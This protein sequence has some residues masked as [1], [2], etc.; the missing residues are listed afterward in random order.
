M[1]LISPDDGHLTVFNLFETD[2]VPLQENVL[3]AMRD[4]IDN[5]DYPGWISSTLHAGVD[6]PG[7]VNYIQWRS[8]ADLQAR[9]EGQKFQRR[10]VP[11]FHKLARTVRLL[12]TELAF[13]QHHPSLDGGIE[14][15][16]Q[17]DDYTVL[18]VLDTKPEDQRELLDTL[19]EPDEWIKTVPGYRSHTYFRGVDGTFVVNY[20]QWESKE[21]YDAF[22]TLPEEKRPAGI[23]N[24]RNRARSL[25]TGRQ[26]NTYRVTHSRSAKD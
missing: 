22:H 6:E 7:T 16:P 25:V 10:T 1:P 18:I 12:K 14:I 5:A 13:T 8:A 19:T 3:D 23:R 4:I 17:R 24:G 21:L 15:S 9:Y 20:A 2:T 26:A 11:L